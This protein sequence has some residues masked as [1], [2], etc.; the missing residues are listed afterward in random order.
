M[1]Q[2]WFSRVNASE[3]L[4]SYNQRLGRPRS[5]V[6]R[7]IVPK[8]TAILKCN[9]WTEYFDE[10]RLCVRGEQDLDQ[11]LRFAVF[12]SHRKQYHW[13]GKRSIVTMRCPNI[14]FTRKT[15]LK[16]RKVKVAAPA[17]V[18]PKRKA[19]VWNGQRPPVEQPV[20]R[21]NP[22]VPRPPPMNVVMQTPLLRQPLSAPP[23]MMLP[24]GPPVVTPQIHPV[25]RQPAPVVQHMGQLQGPL[26]GPTLVPVTGFV[27]PPPGPGAP[28]Q[29]NA[30]KPAAAGIV[31]PV[32]SGLAAAKSAKIG[33][34]T[35]EPVKPVVT[36]NQRTRRSKVPV[37]ATKKAAP[38]REVTGIQQSLVTTVPPAISS[39]QSVDKPTSSIPVAPVLRRGYGPEKELPVIK[40]RLGL[41]A[42]CTVHREQ[43]F[44]SM[45]SPEFYWNGYRRTIRFGARPYGVSPQPVQPS[46]AS[47][48]I[49]KDGLIE[50][51]DGIWSIGMDVDGAKD[52]DDGMCS[53]NMT[54]STLSAETP[55]EDAIVNVTARPKRRRTRRKRNKRV[56]TE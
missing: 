50:C 44:Q 22:T 11:L 20:M 36:R 3:S 54:E 32:Q 51:S 27:S 49:L 5:E 24:Q 18:A 43:P 12:N 38:A 35:E 31:R 6:R 17:T 30:T 26:Q 7:G 42:N 39:V 33:K 29:Q 40:Q 21:S 45:A 56:R 37:P 14:R 1:F 47:T 25:F 19:F 28:S 48:W 41:K 53:V 23:V 4:Y 46:S 13:K 2:V 9:T 55:D 8:T 15:A 52:V 16:L 34:P 10:L